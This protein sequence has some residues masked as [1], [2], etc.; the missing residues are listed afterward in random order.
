MT[1]KVTYNVLDQNAVGTVQLSARAVTTDK[2]ADNAVNVLKIDNGAVTTNK[3]NSG[4]VTTDKI[5]LTA[6]TPSKLS[7]GAP[8]WDTEGNLIINKIGTA[9]RFEELE[10]YS[11]FSSLF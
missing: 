5:A 1:T 6:V 2:I 4:A 10:Q 7:P 9:V 8:V 3:I 11:P